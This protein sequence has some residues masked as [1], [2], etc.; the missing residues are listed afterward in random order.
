MYLKG[1]PKQVRR[2][3]AQARQETPRF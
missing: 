1:A 3:K 2:L